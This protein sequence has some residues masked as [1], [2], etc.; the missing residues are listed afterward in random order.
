MVDSGVITPWL[1]AMQDLLPSH[2]QQ[3]AAR[4][5]RGI[6]QL[7]RCSSY[8][9]KFLQPAMHLSHARKLFNDL[10]AD[11]LLLC[12]SNLAMHA[13][14]KHL[15]RQFTLLQSGI[16]GSANQHNHARLICSA[17]SC[18]IIFD[19]S[20]TLIMSNIFKDS[21]CRLGLVREICTQPQC[22]ICKLDACANQCNFQEMKAV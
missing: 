22:G 11:I 6:Q 7:L 4:S 16:W 5:V 8:S 20:A 17:S 15:D 9:L 2:M 12:L 21:R 3:P 19:G 10:Q 13:E 18:W 1:A 14:I